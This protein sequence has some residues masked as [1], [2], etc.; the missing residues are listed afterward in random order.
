[1]GH[2]REGE[3]YGV[4]LD[5]KGVKDRKGLADHLNERGASI[6]KGFL[7]PVYLM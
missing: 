3:Q 6:C 5:M 7:A 1:M 4:Y 2:V